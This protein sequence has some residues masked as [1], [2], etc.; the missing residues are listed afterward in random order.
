VALDGT[1][2]NLNW[3]TGLDSPQGLTLFRN[4]LYVA[5]VDQVIVIDI[6]KGIVEKR[7][8]A[9]GAIFLNDIAADTNGN[10]YVSDCK[11]NRIYRLKNNR[12]DVW[13][14]DSKLQGPNGLFCERKKLMLLNMGEGTIYRVDKK[15]KALTGFC[16]GIKN[17]DGVVPAEKGGY[18]VSGAWQGEVYHLDSKGE[19][20]LTLNLG[21]EKVIAADIEYIPEK[22]LL[23]VPTLS[24]TVMGYRWE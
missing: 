20:R 15:T 6:Q 12:L 19:K 5:D 1:I 7:F 18:F 10:V 2:L 9:E 14:S 21:A 13:L 4:H 3:I 11:A 23:I 24:K 22:Q 16:S 8:I 17:L